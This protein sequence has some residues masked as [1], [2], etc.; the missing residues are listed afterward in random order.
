MIGF[1]VVNNNKTPVLTCSIIAV[2]HEAD[3]PILRA[4]Q[5]KKTAVSAAFLWK[6]EALT[7]AL[8]ANKLLNLVMRQVVRA[9]SKYH[10]SSNL[11]FHQLNQLSCNNRLRTHHSL[12][13]PMIE[14][15]NASS[16]L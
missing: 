2:T 11:V 10:S 9:L 1:P 3:L 16:R 14:H 15:L 13:Q 6:N 7:I 4:H 12:K 5:T 8:Q